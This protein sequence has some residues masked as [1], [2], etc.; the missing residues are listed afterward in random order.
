[1]A[2]LGELATLALPMMATKEKNKEEDRQIAVGDG[3]KWMRRIASQDGH[4]AQG[5]QLEGTGAVV[6]F[7]GER[8]I[9]YF[10]AIL[11]SRRQR[12]QLR[13]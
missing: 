6:M 11:F 2:A 3:C 13:Y 1:M 9:R 4:Q 12:E 10:P 8:T 5:G 7:A